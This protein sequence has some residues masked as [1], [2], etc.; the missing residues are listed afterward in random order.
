MRLTFGARG[1]PVCHGTKSE[2][3]F[4]QR[5]EQLSGAHLLHGYDVSICARCG[6]GYA[7]KI[8]AQPA[9]DRYYRE[10][11]KYDFAEQVR[12]APP[13]EQEKHAD[14]AAVI[15]KFVPSRDARIFEI[16]SGS[17][18]LLA[19]LKSLGFTNLLA[20]DPSSGCVRSIQTSFGVPA[21]AFGMYDAEVPG[22]PFDFLILVG[23]MEHLR[24]LDLAVARFHELVRH[25]G[26]VYLE[27]PD[28]SRY[29]AGLD[30]PFQEF[31][32]EHINF[33]SAGSLKNSMQARGFRAVKTGQVMRALHEA[34]CP[35][36]YG[37]FERTS[38]SLPIEPDTATESGL[39]SYIKDCEA[40]DSQLRARISESVP[41]G[42]K[43]IV[44]GVGA[45]T[46][47]LLANRGLDPA[48][49][50]VFVDSNPIYQNRQLH[51][52]P[53]ISPA[54]LND[55][56]RPI[57]ISSRGFQREIQDQIQNGLRL[58]NPLILLYD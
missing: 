26:R 24:E 50:D 41:A 30:A 38:G 22:P 29:A 5:F 31:S 8:P 7:D 4:R 46:L 10:L 34:S 32:V 9:F 36:V 51:G 44:W 15:E 28:A 43:M 45:H 40:E 17:G 25:G 57:L 14:I 18:Q 11:S 23:V 54:E 6:A 1:C 55:R 2:V 47:R 33:F 16:G 12:K 52:I 58:P 27:V 19:A 49:I 3:L 20:S 21:I 39:R 42:E 56:Q 37:V 35:S 13:S 53:V 48:Q